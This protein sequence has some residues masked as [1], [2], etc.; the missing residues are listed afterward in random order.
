MAKKRSPAAK[1]PRPDRA[2]SAEPARK[3][4]LPSAATIR[5]TVESI[6]VAFILAFL[7]R[8][9][10]A[11][12]FVI[13]TGSMAPTLQ[14]RH[15]DLIC[16]QCGFRSESGASDLDDDQPADIVA[17]TCPMCRFT[18]SI[19][20]R[21]P[22][23]IDAPTYNGD[24]I[25]V[26]KFIYEFNQPERWDVIVFHFP[27]DAKMNYIK[28]LVGLPNEQL[29]I[30]GG[31]VFVRPL[32]SEQP[33]E[34][35][36]KPPY[37]LRAIAQLVHDNAYI[38][39]DYLKSNWPLRWHIWPPGEAA[40][41]GGWNEQRELVEVSGVEKTR[42]R[43]AIDG[44]APGA[45]WIRYRHI[46]PSARDWARMLQGPLPPN[47][48]GARPQLITDFY[49]YNTS[50][51][52]RESHVPPDERSASEFGLHW[53]GD[54]ML[55][56]DLQVTTDSG[57]VLLDLVEGGRHFT[58]TID[59]AT[60]EAKLTIEGQAD[61][62]PTAQTGVRGPGGYQLGLSNFDSQLLLWV[63]GEPV[64][65]SAPTTYPT[66]EA[67][68]PTE[69]DLAPAGVG[70]RGA[71]LEVRDLRIYRDIYY[72]ADFNRGPRRRPLSDYPDRSGP[73]ADYSR[74]Y[75][76]QFLADPRQW[77]VF[78]RRLTTEY[79]LQDDQFL[80][81][82]DNSPFSKDSRL[83]EGDTFNGHALSYFV[84]RKLLIGKA[85]FIY[86]PHSW[87]RVPGTNIPFPY[88]PNVRDMGLVR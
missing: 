66:P 18:M 24:R 4:P 46:V 86:W 85:L 44:R 80:V 49:A 51:A 58:A 7:F 25:L 62:A 74:R 36:R 52:R 21:R 59:V 81:L 27:G 54:L 29:M 33:Y 76:A 60:G 70:S 71:G 12:A 40:G 9:F 63:D 3:S 39:A 20:P 53:V 75:L 50:V 68:I 82:G 2:A 69:E 11:E 19:D 65:F 31:D 22:G 79:T 72:I 28:R 84:D 42:Q 77:G 23:A 35:A 26:G 5:E 30:H 88:F 41:A 43:F 6:V 87:D 8:T 78:G 56:A 13:P 15:K 14:G 57:E 38:P 48:E 37:K 64:E 1:T 83:W 67:G 45:R 17:A 55:Q 16:P 34:I 73:L 10:E 47:Y 32:K 61:F